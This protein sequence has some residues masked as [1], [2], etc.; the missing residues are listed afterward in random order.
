MKILQLVPRIPYPPDTGSKID[1]LNFARMLSPQHKIILVGFAESKMPEEGIKFLKQFYSQIETF[2]L[3]KDSVIKKIVLGLTSSVPYTMQ[4]YYCQEMDNKL[5]EIVKKQ[6]IDIVCIFQMHMANYDQCFANIPVVLR[7]HNIDAIIMK[8]FYLTE[9]RPHIRFYAKLQWKKLI[10]YERHT[11]LRFRQCVMITPDDEKELK[12]LCPGAKTSIIPCGID[13]D[14]YPVK[15]KNMGTTK[16]ITFLGSM[17]WLPT[18]DAMLYFLQEIWPILIRKIPNLEFYMIGKLP[19]NRVLRL[20]KS[21]Q[22]VVTGYVDSVL[23]YLEETD[24]FVVPLRIGSGM[25]IK[26][27]E[28]LCMGI[29][30]VSTAIGMEGIEAVP[31]KDLLVADTPEDFAKSVIHVMETPVVAGEL[32]QRGRQLIQEKYSIPIVGSQWEKLLT[33]EIE[34]FKAKGK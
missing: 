30:I 9:K 5:C 13:V 32:S 14:K 6:Q 19:S 12:S 27:L 11:C 25:R 7:K 1:Y 18:E 15:R 22:I 2:P 28:A 4:K 17:D 20:C 34:L 16:R 8:R 21:P 26:I 24:V 31:G 3:P 10:E 33:N 29:P 23:P